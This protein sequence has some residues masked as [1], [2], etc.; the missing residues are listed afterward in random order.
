MIKYLG[1]KRTL[2]PLVT[3]AVQAATTGKTILDLFSGT[4]R[5]GHAFKKLGYKVIANDHNLYAHTLAQCYVAADREDVWGNAEKLVAEFNAL[6]GV[7]GYFTKTF[8]QKS[9]FF[10]PKNGRKIDAIRNAIDEKSLDPELRS[11]MLVSLMEAADRVDSTC[12]VQ[13]AYLKKWAPRAHNDLVLRI[14]D[15]LPRAKSG[16]CEALRLDALEAARTAVADVVYVDPPYNQHS[17]LSNYHIWETLVS[18]DK[19]AVYGKA[20]KRVDCR[21]RKSSFNSKKRFRLAL[22]ELLNAIDARTVIMSFSNEGYIGREDL[23][24]LL[25]QRG[26]VT[27]VE[28]PYKRYVGAQIGIHDLNGRKV[29]E[30]SHL[31]NM[32]YLYIVKSKNRRRTKDR[33]SLGTAGPR[34]LEL[35]ATVG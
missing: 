16:K 25:S 31:E 20:C 33:I 17:Y 35:S 2:V 30:V 32:E 24:Q 14:P 26:E 8:C 18:W 9:K 27:V 12:G 29:G 7:E 1:S 11:V 19:P 21:E 6:P 10:R 22:D 15:C 34:V 28:Q 13:M 5:I 4:S 3:A 23:Q